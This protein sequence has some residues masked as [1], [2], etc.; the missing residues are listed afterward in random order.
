MIFIRKQPS[1]S[2]KPLNHSTNPRVR[3]Y[4]SPLEDS[5]ITKSDWLL[6]LVSQVLACKLSLALVTIADALEK[7]KDWVV[8]IN[9][10]FF[11]IIPQKGSLS[12]FI[13]T[14][15]LYEVCNMKYTALRKFTS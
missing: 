9:K 2:V 6:T 10:F 8:C 1:A 5:T 3:F 11:N 4:C 12:Y 15:F 7:K 14:P 13:T